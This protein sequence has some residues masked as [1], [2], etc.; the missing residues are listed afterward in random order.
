V[1]NYIRGKM[2]KAEFWI[3]IL[4]DR[5]VEAKKAG[6]DPGLVKEAQEYHQKAH[7]YWEWWT[8]E[9]S[10]GFHNPSLA[11]ESLAKS[12]EESKK[13]IKVLDDA[14]QRKTASN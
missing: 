5:I 10:D 6:V 9:N 8:A 1:K 14:M 13:G 4:I 12:V 2:R 7:I 11:R 3:S